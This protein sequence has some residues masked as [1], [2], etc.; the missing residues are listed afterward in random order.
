MKETFCSPC[1]LS[2][3]TGSFDLCS[4]KAICSSRREEEHIS[5]YWTQVK[6]QSRQEKK[7]Y[8]G[9]IKH[10]V[11]FVSR[12]CFLIV[13]IV[14]IWLYTTEQKK[15]RNANMPGVWYVCGFWKKSVFSF[16]F[17][18]VITESR[19]QTHGLTDG[20]TPVHGLTDGRTQSDA[21][22]HR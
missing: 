15:K 9:Q 21:R 7:N 5:F 17:F 20:H 22:T 14:I 2:F 6:G 1:R 11:S 19:I 10:E 3:F 13:F 16:L 8:H 4:V 12:I 18:T